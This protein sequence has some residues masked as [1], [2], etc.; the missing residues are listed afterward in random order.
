M[1]GLRVLWGQRGEGCGRV[2]RKSNERVKVKM[3]LG[4]T[5]ALLGASPMQELTLTLAATGLASGRA[6]DYAMACADRGAK[7]VSEWGGNRMNESK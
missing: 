5:T 1:F 2:G 7:G 6:V 4:C 3:K